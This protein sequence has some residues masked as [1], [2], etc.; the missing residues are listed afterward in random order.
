LSVPVVGADIVE[1]N[2]HRDLHQMT[3]MVGAK[4]VKEIA[5]KMLSNK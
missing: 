2:P 1:Y 5:G 3:A 4:L